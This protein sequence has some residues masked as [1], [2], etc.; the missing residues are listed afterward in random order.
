MNHVVPWVELALGVVL[1]KSSG[2]GLRPQTPDMV[3]LQEIVDG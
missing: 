1:P 3:H 2:P